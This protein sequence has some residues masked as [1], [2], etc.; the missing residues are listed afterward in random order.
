MEV[1]MGEQR[2]KTDGLK[3]QAKTIL[4][5]RRYICEELMESY[6]YVINPEKFFK[7]YKSIIIERTDI[8]TPKDNRT[9]RHDIALVISELKTN[10]G[11]EV[12]LSEETTEKA[13]TYVD[14]RK[15]N[16]IIGDKIR[17]VILD[18]CGY[19][20]TI[21]TNTSDSQPTK[22]QF[23]KRAKD[24][25]THRDDENDI[26]DYKSLVKVYIIFSETGYEELTCNFFNTN[27]GSN[28]ILFNSIHQFCAEL[29]TF[30]SNLPSMMERLYY[31]IYG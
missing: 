7:E 2:A 6:A 14:F 1:N 11:I 24:I 3:K 13:I 26:I 9:Y 5:N 18:V 23:K 19:E 25:Y 28:K 30:V 22:S 27:E 10:K 17:Y 12:K 31:T 4:S 20:Y 16:D 21:Y 8:P 15:L 29:V